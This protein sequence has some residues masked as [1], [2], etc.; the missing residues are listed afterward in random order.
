MCISGCIRGCIRRYISG[1][2]PSPS[3]LPSLLFG[4][5]GLHPSALDNRAHKIHHIVKA[6]IDFVIPHVHLS[7]MVRRKGWLW[8][9]TESEGESG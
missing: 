4:L 1:C 5:P 8:L 2:N 7:V 3:H 6:N 9:D